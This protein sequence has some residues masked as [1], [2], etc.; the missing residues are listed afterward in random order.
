L[1]SSKGWEEVVIVISL[2]GER[3][4]SPLPALLLPNIAPWKSVHIII[5]QHMMKDDE[6]MALASN[7]YNGQQHHRHTNDY[8]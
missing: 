4:F 6:A 5:S 1:A 3:L 2:D 7:K 8:C